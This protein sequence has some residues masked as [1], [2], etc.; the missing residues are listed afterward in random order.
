MVGH[1]EDKVLERVVEVLNA[2]GSGGFANYN[3]G[4]LAADAP[5]SPY[6]A[7]TFNNVTYESA[8]MCSNS[9]PR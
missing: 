6:V 5:L 8:L 2:D 1:D 3:T 9:L 4:I 7:E